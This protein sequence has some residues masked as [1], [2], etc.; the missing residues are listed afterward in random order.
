[1]KRN[2]LTALA[3][4]LTLALLLTACVTKPNPAGTT[5]PPPAQTEAPPA[6][7]TEAP[8][9]EPS[10]TEPPETEAPRTEPDSTDEATGFP[11]PET[12]SR[13]ADR[14]PVELETLPEPVPAEDYAQVLELLGGYD[15]NA[16][17]AREPGEDDLLPGGDSGIGLTAYEPEVPGVTRPARICTDGDY[18]YLLDSYGLTI[19]SAAGKKS[20]MLC[21]IPVEHGQNAY[22]EEMFVGPDR[23]GVIYTDASF[24]TDEAGNWYDVNSTHLAVYDTSDKTAP[25]RIGDCGIEGSYLESR[26]VDGTVYLLTNRYLWSVRP[27]GAPEAVVPAVI[28]NGSASLI[29]AERIWLCPNPSST[30][31]TVAAAISLADGTVVDSLAFTDASTSVFVERDCIWLGR[32]VWQ[33][34]ASAP[35]SDGDYSVTEH[36]ARLLTELKRVSLDDGLSP[37][38]ACLLEGTVTDRSDLGRTE[39][40]FC[41]V[42]ALQTLNWASYTDEIR[43]WVNVRWGETLRGSLLTVLDPAL[44][45]LGVLEDPAAGSG[46]TGCRFS[47]DLALL[48]TDSDDEAV[49]PVTLSDPT[50]PAAS[51]PLEGIRSGELSAVLDDGRLLCFSPGQAGLRLQAYDRGADGNFELLSELVLPDCTGSPAQTDSSLLLNDPEGGWIGFS[52]DGSAETGYRYFLV[53]LTGTGFS[54]TVEFDLSYLPTNARGLMLDGLLYICSPGMSYAADPETGEI[55]TTVTNAEG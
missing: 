33:Y 23:V 14:P 52:V 7:G 18:L 30:A 48:L 10:R 53:R 21:S 54:K 28:E 42:T 49:L 15:Y 40:G 4:A 35:Y 50:A 5:A 25:V 8:Q 47:G 12:E 43:G 9:T 16:I 41:V 51:E 3:L 22:L 46:I 55:L 24:G 6:P 36:Q 19:V 17:P 37:D 38:D 44:Q 13:P 2:K 34:G 1:M 27:D 29:P 11:G 32:Q 45:P 31:L 39:A 20:K 26:L